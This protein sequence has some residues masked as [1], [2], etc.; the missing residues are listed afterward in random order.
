MSDKD[1]LFEDSPFTV[2]DFQFD[3]RVV[4]VFPDMINRS[5]PGYA[6]LIPMIGMLARR[7]A[8]PDSHIYDL[9]CSLGAAVLAMRSAV[10][11]NGVRFV[12]VDNSAAMM[13]RLEQE[14]AAE[15]AVSPIELRL[16]DLDQTSIE[17]ASVTVLNL[18]LQ[19]LE[20]RHRQRLLTTIARGTRP[21]GIVLLTEKIRFSDPAEQA[22]Q[23]DWYHD[24]K[25]AQGYSILEIASKRDALERVLQPDTN[26]RH[27]ARLRAAG[28]Q[29]AVRWFQAFNFVSYLAIR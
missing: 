20:P 29:T 8:Q 12:A 27:L 21:G 10:Q 6:L 13:A 26:H 9:G 14:L 19:F 3:D 5:V 11:Q 17:N 25:R 23:T 22:L 18:T 24:F 28:W 1:R 15:E 2:G 16:E 7:Y 4:R